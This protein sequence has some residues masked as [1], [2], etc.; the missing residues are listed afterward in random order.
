MAVFS[1]MAPL[2]PYSTLLPISFSL[3]K[4]L[5]FKAEVSSDFVTI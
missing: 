4:L 2:P 1:C 5:C 3:I